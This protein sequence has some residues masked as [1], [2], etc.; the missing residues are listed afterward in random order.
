MLGRPI[1]ACSLLL[2]AVGVA[3]KRAD[4]P[5]PELTWEEVEKKYKA[6]VDAKLA[7][8]EK[9]ARNK[10]P[11]TKTAGITLDGPPIPA[12]YTPNVAVAFEE[13]LV[14]LVTLPK[15]KYRPDYDHGTINECASTSRKRYSVITERAISSASSGNAQLDHCTLLKYLIVVR[16][17]T[18]VEPKMLPKK[19]GDIDSTF[20]GGHFEGDVVVFNIDTGKHLG[21][22]TV[23]AENKDVVG[24]NDT[25]YTDLYAALNAQIKDGFERNAPGSKLG[26][27]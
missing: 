6:T 16:L 11:P 27:K 14:D 25:I 24:R 22:Y 4:P 15:I 17:T 5:K 23:K 21:G 19:P 9:I 3:C 12:S 2:L 7:I 18:K 10:P 13:D 26:T 8:V 20:S 1:L